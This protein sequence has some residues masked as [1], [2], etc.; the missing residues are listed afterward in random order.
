MG[1]DMY[2]SKRTYVRNWDHNPPERKIAITVKLGGKK[3]PTINPSRITNII[4]EVGYW[5]KANAIHR[6]FV[7][8]VQD[9]KD[10][11][12][13]S[14][15]TRTQ[16]Q[17][18]YDACVLVRDNTKLKKGKVNNGYTFEKKVEKPIL[19]DGKVVAD[20][21][22]AEA[23]L[24]TQ[25]GFFFGGTDYDEYYMEDINNTIKILEPELKLEYPRGVYEPD[26]YYR[27]SW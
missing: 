5:R 14:C 20:P 19:A 23:L 26:Y 21:S 10:E 16:L 27:A 11:C 13:E 18:L 12:Q 7:E 8:K 22:V 3:H 4:E 24:P 6:W 9:G 1:L 17:E 15:V 25:S 2:L